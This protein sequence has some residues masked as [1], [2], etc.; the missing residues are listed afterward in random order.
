MEGILLD[1]YALYPSAAVGGP[2]FMVGAGKGLQNSRVWAQMAADLFGCP[3]KITNFENAVWGA[4]V[5]A[6]VGVGAIR[7]V[8]T[9]V[10]GDRI[11]PGA[12]AR[13]RALGAIS[14]LDRGALQDLSTKLKRV[15]IMDWGLDNARSACYTLRKRLRKGLRK[16]LRK[17]LRNCLRKYLRYFH[18]ILSSLT[19][20]VCLGQEIRWQGQAAGCSQTGRGVHCDGIACHQWNAIRQRRDPPEGVGRHRGPE[21]PAEC[22]RSQPGHSFHSQNGVVISEIRNPFFTSCTRHRRRDAQ[23]ALQ[24]CPVQ[25]R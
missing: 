2:G 25:Y 8:R 10:R 18:F 4:A 3:V 16:Y 24:Y 22:G 14:R 15:R 7:D 23:P 1:L 5:N 21:L 6:A 13:C 20:M 12:G 17:C 11:Q 9:R 19:G